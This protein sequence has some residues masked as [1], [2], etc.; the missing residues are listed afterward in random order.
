MATYTGLQFFR[1]HSVDK[2]PIRNIP[3]NNA[4]RQSR[5]CSQPCTV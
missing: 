4:R 3:D 5:E 1:G 2:Q